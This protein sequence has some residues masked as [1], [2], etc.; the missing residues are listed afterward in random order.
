MWSSVYPESRTRQTERDTETVARKRLTL[1]EEDLMRKSMG[2]EPL[3]TRR[4][5]RPTLRELA[6]A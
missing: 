4:P 3:S 5:V 1:R 6:L 2:V